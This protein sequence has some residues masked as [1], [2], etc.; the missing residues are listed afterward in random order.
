MKRSIG[1]LIAT[2][3]VLA[4]IPEKHI[5]ACS[6]ARDYFYQVTNLRGVVVGSGFPILHLFRSFRQSVV[7]PKAKLMLYV[8]CGRC[9]FTAVGP[10]KTVEADDNGKFDFG[11][12]APGHYFLE[13]KDKTADLYDLYQIEIKGPQNPRESAT[14]DISHNYPDCTGGHEFVVKRD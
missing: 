14:I 9:D 12:V 4:L 5:F 2:V 6:W 10:V 3:I 11:L 13:I 8:Y 1:L 7:R